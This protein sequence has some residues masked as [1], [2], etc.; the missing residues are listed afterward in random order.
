[1]HRSIENYQNADDKLGRARE[2]ERR[3]WINQ[4]FF[5]PDIM[6]LRLLEVG[7]KRLK[8]RLKLRSNADSADGRAASWCGGEIRRSRRSAAGRACK[9]V[10]GKFDAGLCSQ[11]LE[12]I[13]E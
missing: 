9:D 7:N 5:L 10:L 12:L 2:K 6:W 11:V 1:M 3:K 4:Y 8:G 13:A